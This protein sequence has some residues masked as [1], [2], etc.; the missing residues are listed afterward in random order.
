MLPMY[1]YVLQSGLQQLHTDKHRRYYG[2]KQTH[3]TRSLLVNGKIP[4]AVCKGANF[5]VGL[6]KWII[7][8][9]LYHAH[10]EYTPVC[11]DTFL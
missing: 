10:L 9:G 2:H 1:I 8:A 5:H 3:T 11:V 4:L 6:Q 7:P